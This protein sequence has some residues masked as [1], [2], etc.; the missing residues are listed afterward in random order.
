MTKEPMGRSKPLGVQTTEPERKARRRR[1]ELDPE[2]VKVLGDA[3]QS[4][5]RSLADEPLPDRFKV[6][7]AELEAEERR[8]E[9]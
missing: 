4:Y 6:M 9:N 2:V 7:L 8:R 3:L 5:Y 1:A